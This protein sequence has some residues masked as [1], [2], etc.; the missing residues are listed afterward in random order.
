MTRKTLIIFHLPK[1]TNRVHKYYF[2]NF[3]NYGGKKE[4]SKNQNQ[5]ESLY[6]CKSGK[7][8]KGPIQKGIIAVLRNRSIL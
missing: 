6:E 2:E 4:Y 1:H 3:G 8:L 5:K 7:H